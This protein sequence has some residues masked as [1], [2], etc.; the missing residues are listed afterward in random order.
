[1]R[2][3]DDASENNSGDPSTWQD[4][5][6][7]EAYEILCEVRDAAARSLNARLSA[8]GFNDIPEDALLI[9]YAMHLNG[10]VARALI[11]RLGIDGR[12]VSQSIETLI[13]RGYLEFRD[14]P[15]N[16][17]QPTVV[18]AERGRAALGEVTAGLRADR[19]AEFPFRSGD[20]VISAAPKSGMTWV[21]MICALMIF[22]API[23]PA[24][25]P[26]LSP[27]LDERGSGSRGRAEVY[28]QLARQQHRLFIKTHMHLSDIPADPRVTYIV[29]AR[30]P[31]DTAVSLYHQALNVLVT[32]SSERPNVSERP[33]ETARQWLLGR[34][35]EMRP[36]GDSYFGALLKRLSGAWERRAEPN[37]A[38]VH[39]EDLSADLP[40]EM[41]RLTRRLDITVP[42]DRWPS[43]VQ[44]ATFK[45]MQAVAD[46]L[47][48]LQYDRLR[49]ASKPHAAFFRKGSSGDGLAL[50][51]EAEAA[52]YYSRA[53]QVAP[54]E[55]L[56]WLHRDD[57]RLCHLA[58][59]TDGTQLKPS[60]DEISPP[61]RRGCSVSNLAPN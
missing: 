5:S 23:L 33:A 9:L 7:Q 28:A 34:I 42:E 43:L 41:R 46:Q 15:D 60:A 27:W 20:I 14:N 26:N 49:D 39:Y 35:D 8:A 4:A 1:M 61:A 29:V 40:G 13:L 30:N 10:A 56:A 58:R 50:L 21:Q 37:V 12:A 11:R 51:T 59:Y 57:K 31:L 18:F 44:A 38:L 24:S 19:W 45:H 53:A 32:D 52:R 16:P 48:P 55:L 2:I 47:Q 17:R 25:L 3:L 54:E 36:G 6:L 22:Q